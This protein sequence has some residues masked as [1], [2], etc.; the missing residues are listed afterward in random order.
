ML[1]I[2]GVSDRAQQSGKTIKN[3]YIYMCVG[4]CMCRLSGRRLGFK[5]R[6]W[7]FLD[8]A[9]EGNCILSYFY[10]LEEMRAKFANLAK[11]VVGVMW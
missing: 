10:G 3:A 4:I 2:A 1:V 8:F 7:C 5:G 9:T 11:F 6:A